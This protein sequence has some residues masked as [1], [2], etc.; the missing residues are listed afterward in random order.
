MARDNFDNKINFARFF[1]SKP[2]I[3]L[4]SPSR[5]S[6]LRAIAQAERRQRGRSPFVIAERHA[7]PDFYGSKRLAGRTEA[8]PVDRSLKTILAH[9]ESYTI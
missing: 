5:P 8:V 2:I 4:S 3:G 7:S 9:V 1:H 6:R